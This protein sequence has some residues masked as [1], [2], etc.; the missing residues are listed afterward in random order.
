[1][2]DHWYEQNNAKFNA[3]EWLDF[4]DDRKV[5]RAYKERGKRH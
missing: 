4:L 1:M 3:Y 5:K 2:F